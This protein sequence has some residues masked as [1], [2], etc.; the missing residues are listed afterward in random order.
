M[1]PARKEEKRSRILAA[2][3]RLFAGDGFYRTRIGDIAKTANVAT[4]TVYTYFESKEKIL[5]AIFEDSME[6]FLALGK[7]DM[8]GAETALERLQRIV[9]LHLTNLG[10]D[11]ELATVFQIELRHSARFMDVY[12][13]SRQLRE[14][15][16]RVAAILEQG[17]EEGTVRRDL[18]VWFATKA[19]FGILD[20][21]ATNWVLSDRNYRLTSDAGRI[22]DF[23][24][25]GLSAG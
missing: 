6:Q 5:D 18:D 10:R 16:N 19:L 8:A 13:R 24:L 3:V 1:E 12:S 14:Y 11:R 2:A 21:A 4:G 23:A 7:E 20:E 15:F 25:K 17:K 22:I 9:E